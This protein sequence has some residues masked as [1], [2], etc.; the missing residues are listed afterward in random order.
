MNRQIVHGNLVFKDFSVEKGSSGFIA[1]PSYGGNFIEPSIIKISDSDAFLL[2][3]GNDWT[4]AVVN[5][6]VSD[7]VKIR[8]RVTP[9]RK[10]ANITPSMQK[11]IDII[12]AFLDDPNE[13]KESFRDIREKFIRDLLV[14]GRGTI[15]KVYNGSRLVEVYNVLARTV[16]VKTDV[17]GNLPDSSA[18]VQE[19]PKSGKK[20]YF[21]KEELIFIVLIPSTETL[22]GLKPLDTLANSVAS[23]ILRGTYNSNYFIN[24]GEAS[25]I[26]GLE[27]MN[28]AE[29]KKFRQY[30]GSTH[31]GAKNAHK[32]LIVNTKLNFMR[33]ALS[34]RDMEFSEYG[35]ELRSKIF[36][37]Y[38]MQPVIMGIVDSTTG[39]LNS[40]EQVEA[41]KDGALKPI[42]DK[43][44]YAYT[45]EIVKHGFGFDDIGISFADVDLSDAVKQAEIDRSDS[46]AAIITINEIRARRGLS[47]VKWGDTPLIVLPGGSQVDPDTGRLVP[48]SEQGEK[49]PEG[50]N[51]KALNFIKGYLILN[52]DEKLIDIEKDLIQI[53]DNIAETRMQRKYL[54]V[55]TEDIVERL[56]CSRTCDVL[57]KFDEVIQRAENS[58]YNVRQ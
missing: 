56:K 43:E 57:S 42:L 48:P 40:T 35:T 11:R 25:G 18:Y 50:K 4:F 47:P 19:D 38:N 53:I 20:T 2:Y 34:N 27:G 37:V 15:E 49:K 33:M 8:P 14:I 7:C 3:K 29:L 10:D 12:T 17:H 41:Y 26:I 16:K 22:Y 23:D 44:S 51:T 55:V 36:A 5:R 52:K 54:E 46:Q 58:V 45:Q 28:K 32:M 9:I 6:I 31:R 21:D 1:D 13:N 24:G 30:W 39:K